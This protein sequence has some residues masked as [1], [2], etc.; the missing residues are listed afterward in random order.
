VAGRSG[1]RRRR[2]GLRELGYVAGQSVTIEYGV[3]ASA[4]QLPAASAELA[5]R[6]V[7]ILIASGTPSVPPARRARRRFPSS[8]WPPSIRSRRGF[9]TSLAR[10]GGNITGLAGIHV[11]LMGQRL[12][13]LR[14]AVPKL[15]RVRPVSCDQ[16]GQCPI[17]PAR[18]AGGADP[19]IQLQIVTVRDAGDLERAYG[20]ARRAE[21]VVQLDDCCGRMKSYSKHQVQGGT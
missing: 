9:V 1:S 2:K 12:E 4:D 3:T 7:D 5:R 14:E 11:D 20:E 19:G 13:L 17:H 18:G 21:A 8:L 10:P 15:S 16:S 6:K